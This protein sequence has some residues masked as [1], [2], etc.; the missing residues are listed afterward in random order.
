MD[1][2]LVDCWEKNNSKMTW[3]HGDKMSRLDRIQ[4]TDSLST[5]R[6]E[7]DTDWSY[8]QSDHGAVIVKLIKNKRKYHKVVRLD[9]L[10]MSNVALKHKFLVELGVRMDQVS[11]TNM[12][13]HQKLEYLKMSISY[14]DLLEPQKREG[15]RINKP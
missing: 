2:N 8:T 3:R 1:L 12:N 6:F 13:P 15:I 5:E 14:R 7:L 11:E 10:F 4:W 9:T